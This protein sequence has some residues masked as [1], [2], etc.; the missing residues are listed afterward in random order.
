MK[1]IHFICKKDDE[2]SGNK[3]LRRI[4]KDNH[5]WISGYWDFNPEELKD[6]VGGFI[7]LHRTKSKKSF[8][9]GKVLEIIPTQRDELKRKNRVDIKFTADNSARDVPWSKEGKSYNMAYT[10]G[11]V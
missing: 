11:L 10:S 2:S 5:I 8:F 7:Y 1:N 6:L 4:D 3:G 9:G